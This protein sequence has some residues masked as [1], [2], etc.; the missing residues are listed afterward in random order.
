MVILEAGILYRGFTIVSANYHQHEGNEIDTDLRSGL[1]TAI[2]SYGQIAFSRDKVEY[3][4]GD[5]FVIAFTQDKILGDEA[6]GLETLIAYAI[7]DKEKKIDRVVK[8]LITPL[9]KQVMVQF[10][11]KVK[12]KNLS[13]ISQFRPFKKEIDKIFGSVTQTLDQSING[14]FF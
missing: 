5:K 10:K 14:T 1:L 3:L 8:K 11:E 7:L 12:G 4:E 13:E 2:L 9:L 6:Y